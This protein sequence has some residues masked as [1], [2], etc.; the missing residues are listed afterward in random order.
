MVNKRYFSSKIKGKLHPWF[1]TD[2]TDGKSSF[3]IRLRIKSNNPLA[4]HISIVYYIGAEI[5]PFNLNLLELVK[6]YFS[7]VS[8]I[9]RSGNM[10]YYEISFIKSFLNIRK[11]FEKFPLQTT[12]YIHLKLWCQVM[13]IIE[14]KE[15]ITEFEFNKILSIKS[16]F[17]K[18]LSAKLLEINSRENIILII[19]PAFEPNTMKLDHNWIAGFVQADGTFGLNYIKQPRMKLGYTYQRQFRITQHE[20]D[21]IVLKRIIE[22]MGCGTIVKPSGDRDRYSISVANIPDLINIVIPLLK[23][24]SLY[25]SKHINFLDFCKGVYIIN[26]KGHLTSEGLNTLKDLAYTMNTYRK[27]VLM[28]SV[29][30]GSLIFHWLYPFIFKVRK[31]CRWLMWVNQLWYR[32]MLEQPYIKFIFTEVTLERYKKILCLENRGVNQQVTS[33]KIC[34][35]TFEETSETVCEITF[36]FKEYLKLIPKHKYNINRSFLEW[37][38]GFTEGDGSFVISKNKIYFDITQNIEDIQVLYKIKKELGFGKILLREESHRRVGVFYVTSEKNFF[39]LIT[40]FNGNICSNY[41]KKQFKKWLEVYNKQ[42]NNYIEF[43][44]RLIKPSLN[45]A[46]LSGFIDA[47]GSFQGRVKSC[48]TSKLKN[49]P[50]LT[51]SITQKEVNILRDIRFLFLGKTTKNIRYDKSW[52]GW[53]LH[54]SS[55]TKLKKLI[56]Y[57]NIYSLKTKKLISFKRWC[58]IHS[59]IMDKE[60]LTISGLYKIKELSKNINKSLKL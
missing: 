37:F 29:C 8:S 28:S 59:L 39:R 42:Y 18:G 7:G 36:N 34:N 45:S 58:H 50:H 21:L 17:L 20:P 5:N 41:K 12:K 40:I 33:E 2:Y 16:L 38:I 11:H 23:K 22:S 49:A 52:D 19:K 26:D 53:N 57:L 1:I 6:E 46:W 15:R 47:E 13:D 3:S 35:I 4:F 30:L 9:S 56:H 60:H 55:F 25:G 51:F 48:K 54:L 27:F 14:K 31:S 32:Y 43:N 44:T 10:Y 24:K